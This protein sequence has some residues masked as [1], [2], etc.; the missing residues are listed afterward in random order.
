M[1]PMAAYT[2]LSIDYVEGV[3]FLDDKS[4]PTGGNEKG[5]VPGTVSAWRGHM[6][7]LRL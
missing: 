6:N 2:G 3:S 1:L 4:L 7:T 5:L